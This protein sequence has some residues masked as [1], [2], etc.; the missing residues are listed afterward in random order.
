[1]QIKRYV[2]TNCWGG[3][4]PTIYKSDR[5]TFVVQGNLVDLKELGNLN[6]PPNEGMVE[7]PE[8]LIKALAEKMPKG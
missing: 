6:V 8:S 4:C 1:M 7:I 2:G 3:H 5:G